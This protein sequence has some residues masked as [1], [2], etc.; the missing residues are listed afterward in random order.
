MSTDNS[1]SQTCKITFLCVY[2]HKETKD[3]KTDKTVL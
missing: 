2:L 1:R 3:T